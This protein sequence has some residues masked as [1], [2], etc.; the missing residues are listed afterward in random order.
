MDPLSVIHHL[1][2]VLT[3]HEWQAF[4]ET[5]EYLWYMARIN[6]YRGAHMDRLVEAGRR[7]RSEA[8]A[9]AQE[10]AESVLEQEAR[11]LGLVLEPPERERVA[12]RMAERLLIEQHIT[13]P[14]F[15]AWADC[16]SCGRVAVPQGVQ[17]VT[18]NCPWC[19]SDSH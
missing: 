14:T 4:K 6:G 1:Q 13:P 8:W 16:A 12:Q 7:R 3:V 10:M 5:E 17:S 19:L 11:E 18:A 9:I 2:N 15:T